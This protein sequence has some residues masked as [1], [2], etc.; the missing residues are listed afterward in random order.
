[1]PFEW[2]TGVHREGENNSPLASEVYDVRIHAS[3]DF[4]IDTYIYARKRVETAEITKERWR[5]R[6]WRFV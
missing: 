1:M 2:S 3:G 6:Q 4:D 5:S